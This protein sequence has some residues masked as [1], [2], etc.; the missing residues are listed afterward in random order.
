VHSITVR[1]VKEI[2]E[3]ERTE[4]GNIEIGTN[5]RHLPKSEELRVRN[6]KNRR[7]RRNA[8]EVSSLP[9]GASRACL[10]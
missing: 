3:S 2:S 1:T 5:L 8:D 9:F 6:I 4:H 7:L 10:T